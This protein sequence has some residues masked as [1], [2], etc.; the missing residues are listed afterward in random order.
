MESVEGELGGR[1]AGEESER[2]KTALR[3]LSAP[4]LKKGNFNEG[5]KNAGRQNRLPPVGFWNCT[6]K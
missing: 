3:M 5:N 2:E 1:G 4:A 6:T